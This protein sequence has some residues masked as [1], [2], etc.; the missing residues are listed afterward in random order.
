MK[1]FKKLVTVATIVGML[2]TAGVAY[3][4]TLKT[5][6]EILSGLTGKTVEDLYEERSAGKTYGTIANDAGK[7]DEFK[8]QMME[9][10]KAVLEQRVKDG[11]LTQEQADEIYNAIKSNQEICNGTAGNA[12]IG[13]KYGTGFGQGCGMGNG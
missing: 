7:L 9:R 11:R 3:A 8:I 13:K 5:P 2:G 4:A 10:K 6:A 12:E 1:S